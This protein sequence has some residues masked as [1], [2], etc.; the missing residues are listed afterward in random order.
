MRKRRTSRRQSATTV[1]WRAAAGSVFEPIVGA[2]LDQGLGAAAVVQILREVVAIEERRRRAS[3][4]GR[5]R[6]SEG[7]A[8]EATYFSYAM[9]TRL[10]SRWLSQPPYAVNGVAQPLPLDGPD[11]FAALARV[12]GSEAVVARRA[13]QRL[14]LIRV[15]GSQVT[16]L[17]DSYVPSRGV[18]EKLDILGRD[19]A[20]FL[21]TMIHNVSAGPQRAR[22]QRKASYDNI[23]SAS[24]PS[25]EAD[26]RQQALDVLRA[27]NA[28]LAAAD[29]DRN[30]SAPAG[31]RTRVS[32]G[33][34]YAVEPFLEAGLSRRQ[35]PRR[36]QRR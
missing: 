36:R 3:A 20:E 23:G 16:L 13:L 26:L 6:S 22:L 24:L 15:T 11:S 9:G 12:V 1:A 8:P 32:F 31:R 14:G 21:R 34:Y 35:T 10:I 28:R 33:V 25:L 19:G 7:E 29:H 4:A 2:L 18:I 17:A 5:R 30:P 27:A